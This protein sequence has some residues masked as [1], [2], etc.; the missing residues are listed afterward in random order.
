M[1]TV[2]DVHEAA[3][4]LGGVAHR[5]PVVRSTSLDE[6]VGHEVFLKAE[7][8]QRTGSFKFRGAFNLMSQ[9]TPEQRAAGVCTVSAGNHAQAVALSAQL[10][11]LRASILMP[12]DAPAAKLAATVGYGA[13]VHTYDRY[14]RPQAE[15]G[16]AFAA[17]TGMTF[18]SAYD[19]ARIA[20]GAATA[21]LEL[22]EDVGQLDVLVAPI[23]GG[24]GMAGWGTVVRALL[25]RATVLG[26]ESALSGVTLA[27][28]RAGTRQSVDLRPHLADGQMLSTPGALT[29]PVMQRVV[30]D[31]LL[32]EDEQILEAMRFLFDRLK[33]VAEPSG[34]I[35]TAAVLA[36]LVP[37]RGLRVGV[38]LSGGNCGWQRF[39]EL[40]A[41][42]PEARAD[43]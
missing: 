21:A 30:D 33:L 37:G 5:T 28:L 1:L 40:L 26:V 15:A 18:V 39:A 12:S 2:Q 29:F 8:W 32:V 24:G 10:L 27:S 6:A 31:V 22:C 9:L 11:G 16:A 41:V 34:A 36:G 14:S 17:E 42:R 23:G 19:D 7:S 13:Q 4:R 38:V 3:E 20:A 43:H 35:A 25:P